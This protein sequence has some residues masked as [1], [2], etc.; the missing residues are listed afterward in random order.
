MG[1][2]HD[3]FRLRVAPVYDG[4]DFPRVRFVAHVAAAGFVH[5]AHDAF[6][7][8]VDAATAA[9][10]GRAEL[11]RAKSGGAELEAFVWLAGGLAC[12]I[13]GNYGTITVEVAG[14][15][16]DAVS[17]AVADVRTRLHR[18]E[19]PPSTVPFAFWSAKPGGGGA[20]RHRD[21]DVT[22]WSEARANYPAGVA[23]ALGALMDVREPRR[24]RL[25]VWRGP[26]GTGKTWA[27]RALAGAWRDWCSA[28]Y[29]IDPRALLGT[30]PRYLLDVLA[31][32]AEDGAPQWRLLVLEDA[33]DMIVHD[34]GRSGAL[35]ALLN[36]T[37]GILGQGSGTLVL[38]TTNEPVEHLHPAVRRRG[39]CLADVEFGPLSRAECAAWL[40]R[41]GSASEP[42]RP[43]TLA[44]LYALADGG[45]AADEPAPGAASFGFS[46]ALER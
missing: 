23:R 24:A 45:D 44:E 14:D 33:G 22:A 18:P 10:L 34:A 1:T 42:Q 28:H 3:N 41:A 7:G 15:D 38:V 40:R 19:S 27:L 32:K 35:A 11:V 2:P 9:A 17:A 46:R 4:G 8:A 20:V 21:V 26:P 30:D 31:W 16:P 29:V 39:R 6:R 25:L 36:V 12:M 37:D 13:D 43:L 5:L